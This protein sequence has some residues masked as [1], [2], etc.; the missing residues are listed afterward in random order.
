MFFSKMK[1]Y[2]K[3]EDIRSRKQRIQYR[4]DVKGIPRVTGKENGRQQQ[5]GRP[6]AQPPR[7]KDPWSSFKLAHY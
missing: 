5:C 4:R 6:G 7:G 3:K 2:T 1:E